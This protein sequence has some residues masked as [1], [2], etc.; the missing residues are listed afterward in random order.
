MELR[1]KK[2][3]NRI[4][5]KKMG[6]IGTREWYA[7]FSSRIWRVY[8]V[9]VIDLRSHNKILKIRVLKY[10][11]SILCRLIKWSLY[12][13]LTDFFVKYNDLSHLRTK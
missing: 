5:L 4:D 8:A 3:I 2:Y 1:I 12:L 13:I 9:T 11:M 6:A 10:L 7:I